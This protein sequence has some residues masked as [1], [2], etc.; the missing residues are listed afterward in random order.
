MLNFNA[1]GH[2]IDFV[3]LVCFGKL[4]RASG[5]AALG[6]AYRL[7]CPSRESDEWVL[8]RMTSIPARREVADAERNVACS[9]QSLGVR[10]RQFDIGLP[11]GQ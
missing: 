5:I 7:H 6:F 8:H 3:Y 9:S 10:A 11:T 4:R 2:Y 1:R